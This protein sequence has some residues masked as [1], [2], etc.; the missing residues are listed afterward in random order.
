MMEA[1][2]TSE[3]L[4]TFY[5]T[6]QHSNLKDSHR[7]TRCCDYPKSHFVFFFTLLKHAAMVL[8]ILA[9]HPTFDAV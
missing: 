2:N 9:H 3:T 5:Q 7:H 6:A 4:A 1:A 8:T